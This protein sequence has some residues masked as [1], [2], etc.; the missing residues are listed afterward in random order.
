MGAHFLH[1]YAYRVTASRGNTDYTLK[2]YV[3]LF[4]QPEFYKPFLL[5][6]VLL[7]SSFL[8]SLRAVKFYFINFLQ[9]FEVKTDK[10][11]IMVGAHTILSLPSNPPERVLPGAR[12]T[13]PRNLMAIHSTRVLLS[14]R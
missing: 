7:F 11:K 12:I 8:L 6:L 5:A 9:D 14:R 10:M 2:S 4:I 13:H 3:K 1:V